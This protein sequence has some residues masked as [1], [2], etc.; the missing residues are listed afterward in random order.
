MNYEA[1]AQQ[2][3]FS[4]LN[5]NLSCPVYDDV[6]VLP[7]GQPVSGFPYAVIGHDTLA[8]FDTDDKTGA[9][10]T[11]T[12]HVWSRA[13]GFK[14]CKGIMGEIYARL[15]RA[16]LT[17]TGV[18]VVDSLWEFSDAFI[19]VDGETRHGVTRYRLTIQ[20]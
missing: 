17:K 5:G 8:P 9:S 16:V 20:E 3:I 7:D 2:I 13:A 15:H 4:A 6:A 18:T 12:I 14:E 1:V 19:D 11:V 10:A